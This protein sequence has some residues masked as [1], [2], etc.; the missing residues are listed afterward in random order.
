M[1]KF[2]VS[3]LGCGS[4][5]PSRRHLPSCQVVNVR[6][7]LYM[8]DCGEGAQ[9][10]A[11][12]MGVKFNR[13]R[14][15]F[16]SHL[17]G[18]HCLGLPGLLSTLS[19]HQMDGEIT[20]HTFAE[21]VEIFRRILDFFCRERTFTLRYNVIRPERAV[22]LDTPAITV[23][24]VPLYHRIPTVGFVFREKPKSRHLR[25]DMLDFYNVPIAQRRALQLGA[26]FVTADG[27]VIPNSRLTTD[28]DPSRSYA[29]C[30]DTAYNPQVAKD[31]GPVDMM[32]HEATYADD[33]LGKARDRYHSTARQAGEI[34][35]L[36]GARRLAI[37]HYSKSYRDETQHLAQAREAFGGEVIAATEGMKITV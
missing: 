5:T 31:V 15:I 18:D 21:G 30:A 34:A 2:E 9:R 22:I 26:D 3:I 35:R 28:P 4:A 33:A 1:D 11:R 29:Y 8:I 10:Q 20:V 32:Y 19:L 17:H 16:L 14:H 7:T 13:L 37:G 27:A 24:T 12:M 25:R 23:E 36:A 6:D